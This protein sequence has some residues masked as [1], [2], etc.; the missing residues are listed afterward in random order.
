MKLSIALA[1]R[2]RAGLLARTVKET[3]KHI[4][5]PD[6][7]LVILADDDDSGTLSMC[8]VVLNDPR[9]IWSIEPK[10]PTVGEK[11]NRVMRVAPADVYLTA[12]DYAPDVTDGYDTRILD[13]AKVFSDGYAIILG[14]HANWSFSQINAVTHKM[15]EK[16]GGIYPEC[17]PFWFVDHWLEEIAKRTGRG[18]FADVWRDCRNKQETTNKRDVGDW[19]AF[20]GSMEPQR[21]AIAERILDAPDF[22]IRKSEIREALRRNAQQIAYWSYLINSQL[23]SEPCERGNRNDP[24]YNALYDAALANHNAWK[25]A[26]EEAEKAAA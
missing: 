15:A 3:L 24:A 22:H 2:C 8:G 13:A 12:V 6:T 9:I 18:V 7:R 4:R 5:E 21:A 26:R 25:R 23:A 16:M 1:T 17:F 20:F 14:Y 19:G 11:Y 10:P